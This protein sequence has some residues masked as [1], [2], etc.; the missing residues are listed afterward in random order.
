MRQLT[1]LLAAFSLL[2]STTALAQNDDAPGEKPVQQE[3]LDMG[4][5]VIDGD[6]ITPADFY[7]GGAHRA[8]LGRLVELDK[9]FMSRIGTTVADDALD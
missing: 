5:M 2:F 1:L 8:K 7:A 6:L 4:T 3:F 9:S